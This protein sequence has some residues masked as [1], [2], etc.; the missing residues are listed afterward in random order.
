MSAYDD[1]QQVKNAIPVKVRRFL[2]LRVRLFF[3][4]LY[5]HW[6]DSW[7]F[8]I[9][10]IG[11]IPSHSFRLFCYR[12]LFGMSIGRFSTI[13]R[14]C[15]FYHPPGVHIGN[16]T[17]INRDVLL[18]GR[19]GLH[20]G[21]NVS[22]SEGTQIFTLEHNP[23]SPNFD[24]LEGEVTI[25]DRVFTGARTLILPGVTIGEGAVVGAGAVVTKDVPPF[26]FAAGV[27]ARPIGTRPHYLTYELT[28]AKFLG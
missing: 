23:R 21:N 25:G 10:V 4:S 20:I 19:T 24:V 26:T 8:F 9:E 14:G 13:H 22:L 17:V 3:N 12:H 2:P 6:Y 28:Y 18:D 1:K 5:W 7:D 15:R 11:S 27:P 16:H